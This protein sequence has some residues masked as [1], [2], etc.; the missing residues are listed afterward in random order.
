M[1]HSQIGSLLYIQL[2]LYC[3]RKQAHTLV[4]L[5]GFKRVITI[6]KLSLGYSP[7]QLCQRDTWSFQLCNGYMKRGFYAVPP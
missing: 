5:E 4:L 2:R 3:H 6:I 7:D 1:E